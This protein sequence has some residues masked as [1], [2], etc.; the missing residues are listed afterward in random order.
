MSSAVLDFKIYA[1]ETLDSSAKTWG[2]K[3]NGTPVDLTGYSVTLEIRRS[4]TSAAL[5]AQWTDANGKLTLGG[6][7]G[8]IAP[9]LTATETLSLWEPGLVKIDADS[10]LLGSYLLETTSPSGRV[11]RLAVGRAL[12]VP[13]IY[14]A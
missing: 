2:W 14:A 7:S 13:R 1:G 6:S 9:N 12:V 3:T 10:Y 4:G 8:L 5:I 11:Q